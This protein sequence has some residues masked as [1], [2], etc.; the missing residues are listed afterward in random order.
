M[1]FKG[2]WD[3]IVVGGGTAGAPAAIAAARNGAKV[4]IVDKNGFLGGACTAGMVNPIANF[5]DKNGLPVVAGLFEETLK[6]LKDLGGCLGPIHPVEG[7]PPWGKNPTITPFSAEYLKF[8]LAEMAQQAGVEFLFHTFMT[9]ILVD[10]GLMKGII[11]NN[12]SGRQV[13]MASQV[14]DCTGDADLAALA[15]SPWTMGRQKDGLCMPVSLYL[16]MGNVDVEEIGRAIKKNPSDFRWYARGKQIDDA[17]KGCQRTPLFCSGFIEAIAKAKAVGELNL[18]RETLNLFTTVREGEI[19][20]NATR[21]NFVDGTDSWQVAKAE[22]ELRRQAISVADFTRKYIPAFSNAYLLNI[23]PEIGIRET[24]H[25]I[26]DYVINME[27]VVKGKQFD[28]VIG[29]GSYSIDIHNPHD[30]KSTWILV[31]DSYQIPYRCLLPGKIENL[32]VAGRS[33]SA[34]H[35]AAATIRSIPES[36]ATGQAAG[37]AAALAIQKG[38]TA[39]QLDVKTL[40]TTLRNQGANLG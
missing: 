12:K 14:I 34:T 13:L 5:H 37:T 22:V 26:G 35:E 16:Q 25:I 24:R 10:G 23:A 28:D 29:R 36:F 7:N 3:V 27:D 31:D 2:I 6:R 4:L 32:L 21:V 39:R 17:P 8:V 20:I 40:Q 9:D 30:S 38:C 33:V 15:G 18:G 11:V 19:T 1:N